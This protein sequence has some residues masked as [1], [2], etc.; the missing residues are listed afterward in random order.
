M[1]QSIKPFEITFFES[2]D[3]FE[4]WIDRR[5]I[6]KSLKRELKK[7]NVLIVPTEGFRDESI[8]AFPVKTD[9]L[10]RFMTKRAPEGVI[11][12][13]CIEDDDYKELGLHGADIWLGTFFIKNVVL[14]IFCSIVAAYIYDKAKENKVSKVSLKFIVEKKDGTT[15]SVS[16]DGKVENLEKAMDAVKE[17]GNETQPE[18]K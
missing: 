8:I 15:T 2:K 1:N 5:Y 12:D 3:N 7:A 14:P 16:Y 18:D 10:F 13:L 9:E 11:V 4:T 17:I 6:S